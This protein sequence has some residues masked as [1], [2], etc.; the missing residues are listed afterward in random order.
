MGHVHRA[1][2]TDRE[3]CRAFFHVAN[4]LEPA[5]TLFRPGVV[6]RV[7]RGCIANRS[8][9]ASPRLEAGEPSQTNA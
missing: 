5:S 3:L 2:S 7:V 9:V 4:L 1:A 6:A 8:Q